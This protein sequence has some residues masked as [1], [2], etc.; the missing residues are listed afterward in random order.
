MSADDRPTGGHV[1]LS[2]LHVVWSPR[3]FDAVRE[4]FERHEQQALEAAKQIHPASRWKQ[5]RELV[6]A[7][8]DQDC[9]FN[10]CR[11]AQVGDPAA[12]PEQP[13][14]APVVNLFTRER[15]R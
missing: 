5:A 4:D 14:P 8:S 3:D 10:V 12:A 1:V 2:G 7:R 9:V 6:R 11:T 13:N 15:V